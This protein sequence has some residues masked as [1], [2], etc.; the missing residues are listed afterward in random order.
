MVKSEGG[1]EATREKT[2]GGETGGGETGG[3][4]TGKTTG[5][6][7]AGAETGKT[8]VGESAKTGGGESGKTEGGESGKTAGRETAT[9]TDGGSTSLRSTLGPRPTATGIE[10]SS[11]TG[12]A[13]PRSIRDLNLWGSDLGFV[14]AL[15]VTIAGM[16]VIT[17]G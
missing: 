13:S 7:T 15:G 16:S 11:F 3:K 6:E 4:E 14:V 10:T 8:T 12:A 2:G 1:G 9:P 5:G 17:A